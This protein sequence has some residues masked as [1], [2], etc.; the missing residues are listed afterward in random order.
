M[1]QSKVDE[2]A[3]CFNEGFN[4]S[5]SVFSTYCEDF[6]LDKKTGLKLACGLGGGMGRLQGTCGAVSGAYLLI[7][8]KH[9]MYLKEDTDARI[10]T[11]D[12]VRE[13]AKLFAERNET[14]CCRDLLGVDLL[15]D[16]PQMT[17]GRIKET[18]PKLIRDAA[19]IVEQLL[20]SD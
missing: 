7:G 17:A 10:K 6:G 11:Y 12:M 5:S 16:D 1:S 4:C 19:E 8:L 18:C 9:G 2:A 14:T 20:Y 15:N 3:A 13:F